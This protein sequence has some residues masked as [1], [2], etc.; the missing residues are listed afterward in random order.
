MASR[1]FPTVSRSPRHRWTRKSS[2]IAAF[3]GP[4]P[5]TR[6]N[7][8]EIESPSSP[9][10]IV[11][12]VLSAFRGGQSC[13]KINLHSAHPIIPPPPRVLLILPCSISHAALFFSAFPATVLPSPL[14]AHQ[15]S[16]AESIHRRGQ[17]ANRLRCNFMRIGAESGE[18]PVHRREKEKL[19]DGRG[20]GKGKELHREEE[21]H[22]GDDG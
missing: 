22:G 4:V 2:A 15:L 20:V 11:R 10:A 6:T 16:W 8:T 19:S 7:N 17:R 9:G 21:S 12:E 13:S 1:I 14:P 18:L 5:E 3:R